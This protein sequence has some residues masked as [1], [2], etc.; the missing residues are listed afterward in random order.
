MLT[1]P[2]RLMNME[3]VTVLNAS[4]LP[5]LAPVHPVNAKVPADCK[6]GNTRS[7]RLEH[8]M[9]ARSPT[10]CTSGKLTEERVLQDWNAYAPTALADGNMAELRYT[11]PAKA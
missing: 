3:G 9:K 6:A 4:K 7:G 8:P 2:D 11:H 1:I 5:M 10:D